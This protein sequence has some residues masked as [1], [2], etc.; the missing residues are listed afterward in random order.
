MKLH[1]VKR[2]NLTPFFPNQWV[3]LGKESERN[4]LKLVVFNVD[5]ALDFRAEAV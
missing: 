5:G 2:V 3:R 4:L 1:T